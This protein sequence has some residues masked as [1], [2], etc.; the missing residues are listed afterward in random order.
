MNSPVIDQQT[1]QFGRLLHYAGLAVV[2][3]AG[4]TTYS[5]LY[6]PLENSITET[7]LQIEDLEIMSRNTPVIRAEH[8]RLTEHL[9]E[10]EQRYA[11]LEARVPLN[12]EAGNFL[13][14]VSQIAQDQH[15]AISNFQPAQTTRS[16]GYAAMEVRL[17]GQGTFPSICSF[18]GRL[19]EIQRLSKVKDL[20]VNV[21]ANSDEYPM[22]ATIV[23][24]FGL[25][26]E[27]TAATGREVSRG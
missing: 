2:L 1:L 16:D 17:E 22:Q 7:Q 19:A 24:Y 3:V 8:S 11:A 6:T 23:I 9:Q 12:A 5:W 20:T 4:A 14:Q 21:D 25:R 13:R 10:I 27:Q 26:G 18:F 15:L